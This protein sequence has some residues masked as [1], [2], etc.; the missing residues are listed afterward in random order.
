MIKIITLSLLLL[1]SVVFN[2]L[3]LYG[4]NTDNLPTIYMIGN[5]TMADKPYK[6]GNPEKGWGQVFPLYFK[7]GVQIRNYAVNGRSSK[8]FIDEGRWEKVVNLLKPGD[9]LIIEFGHNDAKI[10]DPKRYCPPDSYKVNLEKY[11]LEAREKGAIPILAT[12]ICRRRFDKEGRFYDVHGAYPDKC[13]EVAEKLNV[14]L[15]D[16]HKRSY[17]LFVRYGVED[18]KKLFLWI[19]GNEYDN[20]PEGKTDDTHFSPYGAFRICDLAVDEIKKQVPD[21]IHWFKD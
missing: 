2:N 12:P 1:I 5:S 6:D 7:E 17:D 16:L 3:N 10:E 8:S 13:R 14:P 4:Q 15:L 19:N 9:Y 20:L 18:S 21:L 11:V